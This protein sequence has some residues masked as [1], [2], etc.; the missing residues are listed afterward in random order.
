MILVLVS[1]T[2]VFLAGV[3]SGVF[4]VI[5]IGIHLEER[6]VLR[7]G[8]TSSS[9]GIASRELLRTQT[10]DDLPARVEARR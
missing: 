8:T 1:I 4:L 6:R 3:V 10:C 9:A 2:A 5:V 7:S